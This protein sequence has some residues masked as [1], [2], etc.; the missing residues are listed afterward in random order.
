MRIRFARIADAER[1][2]EMINFYAERGRMLHRSLESVYGNL[3]EFLVAEDAHK[4][5]V[6]CVAVSIFWSDLAEVKSLAVADECRQQGIGRKLVIEAVKDARDLGVRRLFALTYERDFFSRM[7]FHAIDRRTL[8]EKVW[9]ECLHCP[10]VD[11]CDETAMVLPLQG[12]KKKLPPNRKR[13]KKHGRGA[14]RN[15][16]GRR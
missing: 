13:R 6:G 14:G 12:K 16:P 15:R 4:N 10:K 1:I 3:R 7:G 8:P 9:S 5:V 2:C 11:H